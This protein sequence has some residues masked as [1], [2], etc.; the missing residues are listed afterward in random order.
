MASTLSGKSAVS[1]FR[2]AALTVGAVAF[3]VYTPT[4]GHELVWDDPLLLDYVA[5]GYER[6]GLSELA[7]AEFRVQAREPTGYY[8]PVVLLS[9]LVDL[10]LAATFPWIYHLTN[11]LLHV[12][13]SV[14][15]LSLVLALTGSL[16]AGTA[17]GLLFAIHPIHV[18][19]VAFVSGR[20]D[21][22][23]SLFIL[24]ATLL[25]LRSRRTEGTE[26]H[27][28]ATLAASLF[29]LG[30][31]S[32]EVAF[33]LPIVLLLWDAIWSR[34]EA[35]AGWWQRNRSWLTMFGLAIVA[36]LL[37]RLAVANIDAE[38]VPGGG[39]PVPRAPF[40]AAD[41]GTLVLRLAWYLRLL[42][43][44]WPQ[45]AYYAP[46]Q[47]ALSVA[48]VVGAMLALGLFGLAARIRDGR[49]GQ[50]GAVWALLFTVPVLGL[51]PVH[52]APLAERF[53]YL[54]SV[55]LCLAV[56]VVVDRATS[57][58]HPSTGVWFAAA[59]LAAALAV[60][61]AS[62][63][64]TWKDGVTF[65]EELVR[66]SPNSA[67]PLENLG[68]VYAE[69]GRHHDALMAFERAVRV[70]PGSA[71]AHDG[72]GI[73]YA[74]LD[75]HADALAAFERALKL[76]PDRASTRFNL[77]VLYIQTGEQDRAVGQREVLQRLDPAL[78]NRLEE[79]LRR[80]Q[81]QP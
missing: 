22:W 41:A 6:G 71:A 21:L 19:S 31:L 8:R 49:A 43:I 55:G 30:G 51:V 14:L 38:A 57:R 58:V 67:L 62:R 63:S 10:R 15:V 69:Q 5:K 80:V 44:P 23:A 9:L 36:L 42:V 12:A 61:A 37:L 7:A 59:T 2:T 40:H 47:L 16:R 1:R 46:S 28:W 81:A 60:A 56:G 45:N 13:N 54:P 65:F 77:A 75:R 18:E 11:V 50:M 24:G 4:L 52:G 35:G 72:L 79:I 3:A 17:G 78:A 25:W 66:T 20:T 70:F 33:A 32:K 29:T 39:T 68:R 76:E 48:T 34:A 64:A 53:L 73:G 26:C 74:R 27:G